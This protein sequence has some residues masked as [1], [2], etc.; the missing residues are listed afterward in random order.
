LSV[1]KKFS[2]SALRSGRSSTSNDTHIT[3]HAGQD[4]YPAADAAEPDPAAYIGWYNTEH[5]KG[6]LGWRSPDEFEAGARSR[7]ASRG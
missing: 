1:E 7:S 4:N 2:I 5:I 3:W 6:R